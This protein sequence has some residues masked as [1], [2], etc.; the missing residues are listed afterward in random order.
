MAT[1]SWDNLS[2]VEASAADVAAHAAALAAAYNDPHNAAMMGHDEPFT[3]AEVEE[4]FA[5][6]REEG[7]RAFLFFVDG[8]LAGDG[9]LRDIDGGAAEL[10]L[11][12][13]A[14]AAQGRGLGTRFATMLHAFAFRAL[15]LRQ[16]VV[17]IVPGN[18]A[19]RRLFARLGYR[20]DRSPEAR[21]YAEADEEIV[22]TL[23]VEDARIPAGIEV[24]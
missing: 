14:R 13:G 6:L 16:L 9:D 2:A 4:H 19:S 12:I 8:E 3:P 22:M 18:V 5:A 15:G 23:S 1:V 10:A 24:W 17:T 11:M 21:A 7:G 20:E